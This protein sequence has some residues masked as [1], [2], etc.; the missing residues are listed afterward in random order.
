MLDDRIAGDPQDRADFAAH[1]IYT[2][3]LRK[4]MNFGFTGAADKAGNQNVIGGSAAGKQRR[5][6]D[7]AQGANIFGVGNQKNRSRASRGRPGP[8]GSRAKRRPPGRIRYRRKGM[9]LPV[10]ARGAG[11]RSPPRASPTPVC[12][13]ENF[14]PVAGDSQHKI[15]SVARNFV[16][17][18][19]T[20]TN[21]I[22]Q[23]IREGVSQ[24]GV[25]FL[26]GIQA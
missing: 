16:V 4:A 18:F 14:L 20:V 6:P 8:C 9:W 21:R 12:P 15:V 3:L 13:R 5:V 1:E 24:R 26:E 25:A 22:T 17:N 11:R 2:F 23:K 10:R 7:A 19:G